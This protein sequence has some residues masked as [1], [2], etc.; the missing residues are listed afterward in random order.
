[1]KQD[2][3]LEMHG[4]AKAYHSKRFGRGFNEVL[5]H[6]DLTVSVGE[7]VAVV[8]ESGI[9]K[10]TLLQIAAGII[11]PDRGSVQVSGRPQ[12]VFQDPRSFLTPWVPIERQ[13]TEGLRAGGTSGKD[14]AYRVNQIFDLLKL[15]ASAARALPHEL[16]VG[17]CQRAVLA[18]ALLAS[19]RL[20]LCD[21]P[22]SS[23]DCAH[24]V[25]VLNLLGT[26][27][28]TL[29]TAMIVVTHDLAAARIVADRV[30]TLSN[31][32]LRDLGDLD[33]IGYEILN[34]RGRLC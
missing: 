32:V 31:G 25:T 16:S 14:R 21:E 6:I 9:G 24:A 27:R 29:G 7:C 3:V 19:P 20:L 2:I 11:E 17:E 26:I 22:I 15:D 13:V 10:S 8:G 4:V 12:I 30:Q 34:D 33:K 18:R 23:V 1:M 5:K 28:R